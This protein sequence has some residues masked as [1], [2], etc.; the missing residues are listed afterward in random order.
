[1]ASKID[2]WI[3]QRLTD[4]KQSIV[5]DGEISNCKSVIWPT[6]V[7]CHTISILTILYHTIFVRYTNGQITTK[8]LT[9]ADATNYVWWKNIDFVLVNCSEYN[10]YTQAMGILIYIVQ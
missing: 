2:K 10:G 3:N 5:V 6:K 7:E 4:Q 8:K 1:M 9:F